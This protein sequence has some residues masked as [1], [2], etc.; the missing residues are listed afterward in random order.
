MNIETL[1]VYLSSE[2]FP[3]GGDV[4]TSQTFIYN[5]LTNITFNLSNVNKGDG[6]GYIGIY[7]TEFNFDG[8]KT[9]FFNSTLSAVNGN[10]L[11]IPPATINNL[12]GSDFQGI[13][14][15]G[16]AKFYYSNGNT[17]TIVLNVFKSD[18]NVAELNM[19][20]LGTQSYNLSGEKSLLII[21]DK[22]N[23]A[24]TMTDY[25]PVNT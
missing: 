16:Y 14:A 12:Y 1:T 9:K 24:Y 22:H 4:S 23:N 8:A 18:F 11:Y 17:A 7:K 2:T 10:Y 20:L 25:I 21:K 3:S 13:S 5:D 19:K 6:D 15:E